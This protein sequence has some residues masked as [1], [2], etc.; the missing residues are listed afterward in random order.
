MAVSEQM[1]ST[2]ELGVRLAQAV[3]DVFAGYEAGGSF[4]EWLSHRAEPQPYLS[5]AENMVRQAIFTRATS[6]IAAQLDAAIRLALQAPLPPWLGQLIAI[7]HRNCSQI[8]TFNYD[9]LVECAFD[10]LD[11]WDWNGGHNFT[12]G[13][14]IGYN[15][16]GNAG[17]SYGEFDGTA[18]PYPSFRLWKLHGST[19]WFWAP[20]D[21]SGASAMRVRLPGRF[22]GPAA[23]EDSD[24]HWMA[25]GLTRL[26][27]PPSSLKSPY[28]ANPISREVWAQGFQAL[29]EVDVITL[30]G[31]SLPETDLTTRA[32]LSDALGAGRVHE[33][34]VVDPAAHDVAG[35]LR[36]IA[37]SG[38]SIT[39]V[40]GDNPAPQYTQRLVTEAANSAVAE[41]SEAD[42]DDETCIV[43]T[44]GDIQAP[45]AR[46]RTAL[47]RA[48]FRTG[49]IVEI[50]ADDLTTFDTARLPGDD[51]GELTLRELRPMLDGVDRIV[52]R[53]GS[54]GPLLTIIASAPRQTNIGRGNGSWIQLVP[55]EP[56]PI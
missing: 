19:N 27:V 28:Y 45:I 54:T 36:Q 26:L 44:W 31:Y 3:P 17:A 53:I 32:M 6:E 7:W 35:R 29:R 38:V 10:S 2:K 55:A 49:R 11:F 25:P 5:V 15:P 20:G 30:I 37:P 48:A 12:W 9:T 50:T 33:V 34:R 40:G 13:S 47:A 18:G 22:E 51:A 41:L 42:T 14:L 16:R 4:E 52:A 1:P 43:V 24:L 8:L 21:A 23:F 39:E 46:G 56:P